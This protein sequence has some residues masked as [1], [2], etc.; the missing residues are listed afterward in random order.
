[1]EILLQSPN[2]HQCGL[3][4]LGRL[5]VICFSFHPCFIKTLYQRNLPMMCPRK[6]LLAKA[7]AR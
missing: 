4:V 3:V 5:I 1:M 2:L 6:D 7:A